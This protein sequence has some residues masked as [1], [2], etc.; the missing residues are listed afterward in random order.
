M[1]SSTCSSLNGTSSPRLKSCLTSQLQNS[2]KQIKDK[3]RRRDQE[4]RVVRIIPNGQATVTLLSKIID[5]IDMLLEDWYP[6]IGI[7]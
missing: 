7:R 3:I 2:D 1:T 4:D 6:D 5:H